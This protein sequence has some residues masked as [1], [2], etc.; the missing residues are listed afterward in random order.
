MMLVMLVILVM[1]GSVGVEVSGDRFCCLS[2]DARAPQDVLNILRS[3]VC[4]SEVWCSPI[5]M[6]N[7]P[8]IYLSYI[9][10]LYSTWMIFRV[11]IDGLPHIFLYLACFFTYSFFVES[12]C[13]FLHIFSYFIQVVSSCSESINEQFKKVLE[14]SCVGVLMVVSSHH[15]VDQS[16]EHSRWM[17]R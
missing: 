1:L 5:R 14:V 2:L 8:I 11:V 9:F 15:S 6:F 17:G 12:S 10:P 13:C 3:L 4:D 7:V 16:F